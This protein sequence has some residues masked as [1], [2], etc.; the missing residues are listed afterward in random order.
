MSEQ[1]EENDFL[2]ATEAR[3]DVAALIKKM[4]EQLAS[5]EKKIDILINQSQARPFGEK[6]FAKPFRSFGHPRRR[7]AKEQD[8]FSGEKRSYP[9]RHFEKRDGRENR[10]FDRKK[11]AYDHSPESD[12]GQKRHFKKSYRGE[13]RGFDQKKKPFFYKRKDR[14]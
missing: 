4:Q 11:K 3:Q 8:N 7:F 13:K 9:G 10:E 12:F 14:G 6:H 2:P 1:S 5:L